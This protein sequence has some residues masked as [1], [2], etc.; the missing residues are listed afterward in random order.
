VPDPFQQEA[1]DEDEDL[2]GFD[3]HEDVLEETEDDEEDL[4]AIFAAFQAQEEAEEE[5]RVQEENLAAEV[6]AELTDLPPAALPSLEAGVDAEEDYDDD[7][8]ELA[9]ELGHDAPLP[10]RRRW[11]AKPG[12]AGLFSKTALVILGSVTILNGL[13]AFVVLSNAAD[14]RDSVLDAQREMNR[15]ASEIRSGS[16]DQALELIGARTPLVPPDAESHPT[17]EN[18]KE[19]ITRGQYSE[20]RRQ[21]YALLSVVDRLEPSQRKRVESRAQY[22]L[23]EALHLEALSRMEVS[24]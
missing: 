10:A 2:F 22:L 9:D 18:A 16:V 13:V 15:T 20:A 19:Q 23:A 7:E 12:A 8:D 21:I 4:E 17:F 5:R 11:T 3:E 14:M 1:Y 24:Q 6:V